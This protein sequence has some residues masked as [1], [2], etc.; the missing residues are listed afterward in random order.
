M[1]MGLN[2]QTV[3]YMFNMSLF[4]VVHGCGSVKLCV[5]SLYGECT[6]V[7]GPILWQAPQLYECTQPVSMAV[8]LPVYG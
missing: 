1:M 6:S 3:V 5:Q 4:Q 2:Q 8:L 7:A